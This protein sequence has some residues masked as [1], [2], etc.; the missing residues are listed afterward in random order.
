MLSFKPAFSLSSFT[1]NKKPFSSSSLSTIRVIS[2]AYRR[3]LTF[4]PAILTPVYDSS[5]SALGMLYSGCKLNKQTQGDN[6]PCVTAQVT[7]GDSVSSFQD[8]EPVSCSMSRSVASWP[9]YRFLRRQ[10]IWYSHLFWNFPQ[11]VALWHNISN[12]LGF[13]GGSVG[14]ASICN[15][16]DPGLIPGSGRSPGGGHGNSLQDSCLENPTDRG[17]WQVST[18]WRRFHRVEKTIRSIGSQRVRQNW[19]DWAHTTH[20]KP[21]KSVF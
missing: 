12:H 6:I 19:K 17:A 4:L 13:P 7:L 10:V 16:G 21:P 8:F 9:A 2:P 20:I 3:L 11:F 15:A 18:G 1:L 5:R 14:K